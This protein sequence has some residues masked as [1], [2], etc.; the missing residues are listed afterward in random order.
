MDMETKSLPPSIFK[1]EE[2]FLPPFV[3]A[4]LRGI[5][6]F[7]YCQQIPFSKRTYVAMPLGFALKRSSP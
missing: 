6:G 7:G 1:R 5:W 4:G 2:T 3:K